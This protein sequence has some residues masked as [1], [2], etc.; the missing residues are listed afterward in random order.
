M[1][2]VPDVLIKQSSNNQ[3]TEN[4]IVSLAIIARRAK[5]Q[6]MGHA[7][8]IIALS[9]RLRKQSR[10]ARSRETIAD[11]RLATCYLRALA[12]LKIAEEAEVET[13]PARRRQLEEEAKLLHVV[14]SDS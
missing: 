5:E 1:C 2:P 6:P 4:N 12:V 3:H 11:L 14:P 9:E 10:K 7:A 8:A 13:D